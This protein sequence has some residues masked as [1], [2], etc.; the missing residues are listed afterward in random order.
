MRVFFLILLA[1]L[2]VITPAQSAWGGRGTPD[3]LLKQFEDGYGVVAAEVIAAQ[4]LPSDEKEKSLDGTYVVKCRVVKMVAD[5]VG[6]HPRLGLKVDDKFDAMIGVGYGDP[7]EQ[8]DQSPFPKGARFYLTIRPSDNQKTFEHASGA[9]AA[10]SVPRFDDV[11]DACYARLRTV[12][13]LPFDR[14]WDEI[15]TIAADAKADVVI[16]GHA[17]GYLA[18]YFVANG[19]PG[20]QYVRQAHDRLWAMWRGP[21]SAFSDDGLFQSLDHALANF[22][23]ADFGKSPERLQKW[24]DRIFAPPAPGM[25]NDPATIERR[26]GL[27]YMLPRFAVDNQAEVGSRMITE[28][29]TGNWPPTF[30]NHLSG[31][32]LRIYLESFRPEPAWAPALQDSFSHLATDLTESIDFRLVAWQLRDAATTEIKPFPE[33]GMRRHFQLS[34]ANQKLLAQRIPALQA[35]AKPDDP[36]QSALAAQELKQALAAQKSIDAKE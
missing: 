30:R 19:L 27:T 25:A 8:Y 29:K 15:L 20:E 12:A 26:E 2:S 33:I 31:L 23:F 17:L 4:K 6:T 22:A 18:R 7:V 10:L 14:R 32:L 9:G 35:R 24:M 5:T 1:A 13:E 11:S 16:R 28:L 21:A 36:D 3:P 34:E